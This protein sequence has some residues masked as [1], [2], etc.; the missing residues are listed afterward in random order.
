M[1]AILSLASKI[2]SRLGVCR[3]DGAQGGVVSIWPFLQS[4]LHILP[5]HFLFDRN[6]SR[7]KFLRWVSGP[8]SHLGAMDSKKSFMSIVLNI[9]HF[10]K[11]LSIRQKATSRLGKDFFQT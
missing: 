11:I 8:L 3:W 4:L 6:N 9:L 2:V 5:M 10:K 1:T 7:L